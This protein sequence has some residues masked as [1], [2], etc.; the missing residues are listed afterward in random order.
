MAVDEDEPDDETVPSAY[1]ESAK[2]RCCIAFLYLFLLVL[3]TKL[4]PFSWSIF[5][6]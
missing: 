2:N 1:E 3:I 6:K 5:T 4:R